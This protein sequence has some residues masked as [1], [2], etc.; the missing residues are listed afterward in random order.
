M[1][2]ICFTDFENKSYYISHLKLKNGV[3]QNYVKNEKVV[4][5][6]RKE[7]WTKSNKKTKEKYDSW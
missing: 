5:T 4:K 1:T 2:Y 7:R 6:P 3:N